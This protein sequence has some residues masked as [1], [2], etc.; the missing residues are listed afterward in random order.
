MP[1]GQTLGG[2][3][4]CTSD[5][6]PQGHADT[7]RMRRTLNEACLWLQEWTSPL[8]LIRALEVWMTDDHTHDLPSA[9]G[10]QSPRPF[11][12]AYHLSHGTAFVA[13]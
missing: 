13:A 1:A 11:E 5:H 3:H 8:A 2:H 7:E 10:E 9:L 6:N 12:H 4:V